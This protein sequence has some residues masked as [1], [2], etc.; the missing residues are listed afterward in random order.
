MLPLSTFLGY[1]FVQWWAFRNSDG[2]G[3]FVQR[4]S[5]TAN[6]HEA[7]K[8]AHAFNILN[9]VVRT[10]P[11][12]LV[13]LAALLILPGLKDPELAYPILMVRYLPAGLLGLVVASLVAAFM[14]TVSTQVNWGASYLVHDLYAR[15][16]G[17]QDDRRLMRAAR[18]A[19]VA[20]TL[21]AAA[22]SFFMD[23]VAGV[24]RF[25]ILV[26]TGPGLVLLL[27]WFWWR[28]NAWAEIAA[29]GAGLLLAVT[30]LFVD[31]TFGQ[32]LALTAFGALAVWLPVM[33]LTPPETPE[34][35]DRFYA[36]IR[37]GGAWG[38]VRERTGLTPLDDLAHDAGRWLVWVTVILGGML[39][40]G[41]LLL[42]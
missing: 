13:G 21:T 16:S 30:S 33:Y 40:I 19:T 39:G 20:L 6:E 3:M 8:A 24:F 10:W 28:V 9:Y 15:F 12:V 37:P 18:W 5:A 11:W 31:F 1:L 41:W 22:V 27:R 2:G 23:S 7:A 36:R 25:V 29:M 42:K 4:L 38:P 32:R 26:G 34:V 17:E 35:L 14:S